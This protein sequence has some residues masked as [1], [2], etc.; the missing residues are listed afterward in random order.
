MIS[1]VT[2]EMLIRPL[3]L[4]KI[5]YLEIW[6]QMELFVLTSLTFKNFRYSDFY[7]KIRKSQNLVLIRTY[8]FPGRIRALSRG[9]AYL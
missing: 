3:C 4:T 1:K 6:D 5:N 2:Y 9:G 8:A 7:Q